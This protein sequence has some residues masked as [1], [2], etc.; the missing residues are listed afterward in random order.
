MQGLV[1]KDVT[2][3]SDVNAAPLHA[4]MLNSK[5]RLMCDLLLHRSSAS[6]NSTQILSDVPAP[7]S[8]QLKNVL[9]KFK[10][11]AD[12][13][14]E[15]ASTDLSIVARWSIG[16]PSISDVNLPDPPGELCTTSLSNAAILFNQMFLFRA[17]AVAERSRP[18]SCLFAISSLCCT[19]KCLQ[20]AT[21]RTKC[22]Q[23]SA[24]SCACCGLC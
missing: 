8:G 7:S 23:Q 1:T 13:S 21:S 2:S 24:G 5:G 22:S 9:T 17:W 12:V 3:L 15:D 4:A 20:A 11:R 6:S 16:P 19:G 14:I 10:L 18:Y